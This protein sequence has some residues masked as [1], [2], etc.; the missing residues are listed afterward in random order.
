MTPREEEIVTLHDAGQSVR[1]IAASLGLT[2]GYVYRTINY[3][4]TG[5]GL[6]P[7]NPKISRGSRML[8]AAIARHHP[9]MVAP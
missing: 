5:L 8:L 9:E 3:Y 2:E 4:C 1:R 7:A 6:D